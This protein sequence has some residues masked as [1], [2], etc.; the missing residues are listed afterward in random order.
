[1]NRAQVIALIGVFVGVIAA[2]YFGFLAANPEPVARILLR[3][4]YEKR[5]WTEERLAK[6]VRSLCTVGVVL[7]LAAILLAIVKFVG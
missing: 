7:A 2:A 3:R 6:R 4:G 5:G 1:M